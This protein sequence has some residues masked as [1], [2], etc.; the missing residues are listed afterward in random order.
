MDGDDRERWGT[1]PAVKFFDPRPMRDLDGLFRLTATPR[2]AHGQP[3]WFSDGRYPTSEGAM[4]SPDFYGPR[5]P[6]C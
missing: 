6:S 2:G 1:P 4:R 5:G 3:F